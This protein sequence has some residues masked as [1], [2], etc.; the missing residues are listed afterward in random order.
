[1]SVIK[2]QMNRGE[3]EEI[4]QT[5]VR[6]LN[7]GPEACLTN[8]R[9][10]S[11]FNMM[12][13][14]VTRCITAVSAACTTAEGKAAS[15][16]LILN[17][18]ASR[19]QE[20]VNTV[21]KRYPSVKDAYTYSAVYIVEQTY[22]K[23]NRQLKLK[24][25]SFQQF[26]KTFYT[27]V[28]TSE[29][30]V[31]GTYD[32]LQFFE[33]EMLCCQAFCNAL[34]NSI[35]TEPVERQQSVIVEQGK[36][37]ISKSA[38]AGPGP[39]PSAAASFKKTHALE[40][41]IASASRFSM[42]ALSPQDSVSQ[43][44]RP[45]AAAKPSAVAGSLTE[46]ALNR[47]RSNMTQRVQSA[48]HPAAASAASVSAAASKAVDVS[49]QRVGDAA[50]ATAVSHKKKESVK[51]IDVVEHPQKNLM[52]SSDSG[53]SS[54]TT[55]TSSEESVKKKKSSRS[56]DRRHLDRDFDEESSFHYSKSRDRDSYFDRSDRERDRAG[57]S[58][59][60][61]RERDRDRSNPN[62]RH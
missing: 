6:K 30:L 16:Q 10:L 7:C 41:Q 14:S 58:E 2:N 31:R 37:G 47:H 42:R 55:S 9:V 36:S 5:T 32:G 39:S 22:K 18:D 20:E 35:R 28:L 1:M 50:A 40:S 21:V 4:V 38:V 52:R 17:W 13:D 48:V 51:V 46:D 24:L 33:K 61:D 56:F 29:P 45:S 27:Q 57:R 15:Y 34:Y 3:V 8:P 23:E 44:V 25:P 49:S 53:S 26:L 19:Q 62:R 60:S 59:R 54:T 11:F 43:M 12:K